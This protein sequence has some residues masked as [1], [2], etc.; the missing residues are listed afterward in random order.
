MAR[1]ATE[2]VLS[3]PINSGGLSECVDSII[4]AIREGGRCRWLACFNPHAYVVS[5]DDGPF[6]QALRDADWLVP[7][8]TG[9]VLASRLLGGRLCER[10][11]G[12]D[13]FREVHRRLNETGATVFF[14]GA[15]ETTLEKIL[16]KLKHEYPNVRVAGCYAPPF[17]PSFAEMET[18]TMIAAINAASP[19]VL[20]VGMSSP[21]QDRWLHANRERLNVKFAAA[22][23]AVFDFYSGEIKRAH[24]VIQRIGLEWLPRLLQEPRRLWR[25][26][27]VSTPVFLWHLLL[28]RLRILR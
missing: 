5:L 13:I 21:K 12:S 6:A 25:R 10:V 7:D 17:K 27:F 20:W 24:P 3:Y 14:L 1:V 26:N 18:Q 2:D 22:V 8:G 23:G 11:T 28:H 9:V 19:D 15:T 4:G 16:A